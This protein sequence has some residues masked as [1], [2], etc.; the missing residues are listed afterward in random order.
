MVEK[1]KQL[2][3]LFDATQCISCGACI[4]ACSQTN[5]PEMHNR[6]IPGRDWLASN[7]RVFRSEE[8]RPV[9]LLVQCQHCSDAPCVKTCP[10]VPI[11]TTKTVWFAMIRTNALAATTA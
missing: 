2:A 7:I 9:N 10:L 8:R 5:F 11:T 6:S 3:H 1:K 4:V